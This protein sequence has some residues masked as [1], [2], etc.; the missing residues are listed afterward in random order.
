[1]MMESKNSN[2]TISII[3]LYKIFGPKPSQ[4]IKLV[5]DG[6]GKK[7]LLSQFGNVLACNNVS[8]DF[9][10]GKIHVIM[11]LS[12]SGKST[13]IR[14]INMLV[15]P[16]SG[17]IFVDDDEVTQIN[18][19]K[20]RKIRNQKLAMVF[21]SYGLL[22]HLTVWK[23][24]AFGLLQRGLKKED[25]K[26]KALEILS[27]VGLSDWADK[28]P[29]ELSGGMQQR[30][31]LARALV[32]D[33]PILL[34]DEPFSGLDPLIRYE[35]Q[36]ELLRLQK[37]LKK[38]IVFITHSMD[39]SIRMGDYITIL[40]DGAIVEQG[41]PNYIVLKSKDENVRK[42]ASNSNPLRVLRG[43]DVVTEDALKVIKDDDKLIPFS[44]NNTLYLK[45]KF[46]IAVNEERKFI[47]LIK[48]Q[49]NID[50]VT[51]INIDQINFEKNYFTINR[52]DLIAKHL[53]E[54]AKYTNPVIV[55][56]DIGEFIGFFMPNDILKT[57]DASGYR[58]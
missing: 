47:G 43:I 51:G 29:I 52:N 3:N 56:D 21:Q 16:T 17:K 40:S 34:M 41:P 12:G 6:V 39:E 44:S 23:N 7:E 5:K 42:F 28:F 49:N 58:S 9:E 14:C 24:V 19:N 10:R 37:K 36:G 38:T 4:A 8:L 53:K 48:L 11:G 50:E 18:E 13:L 22:S 30:V 54:I 46:V 2:I 1:M 32:L 25:R 45:H 15:K 31:G 57:L 27:L 55:L 26:K 33:T 20:L 35:L